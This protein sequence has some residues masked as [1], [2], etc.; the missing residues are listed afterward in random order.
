[1]GSIRQ[2]QKNNL[3]YYVECLKNLQVLPQNAKIERIEG[4]INGV[5]IEVSSYKG[6]KDWNRDYK[7]LYPNKKVINSKS[8]KEIEYFAKL[9]SDCHFIPDDDKM[10]RWRVRNYI[11]QAALDYKITPKEYIALYP[12]R[13]K[14]LCTRY[15]VEDFDYE[16]GDGIW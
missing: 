11:K 1:M 14:N 7:F 5:M 8:Q 2:K 15:L 9:E 13:V 3:R 10:L 6:P 12:D 4:D 16:R